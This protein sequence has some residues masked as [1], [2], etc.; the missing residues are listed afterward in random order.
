VGE[1]ARDRQF[2]RHP[3]DIPIEIRRGADSPAPVGGTDT[4]HV[5]NVSVGGLAVDM[6]QCLD[7]GEIVEIHIPFVKPPFEAHGRVVWCHKADGSYEMGV[8]FL[9][10]SDAFRARMVE[11]VCHI[12][13]YKRDVREKEGRVLATN[14][15]AREW[16]TK[17][18]ARF[19]K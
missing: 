3:A 7:K 17:F 1:A 18:A 8:Q 11:Q 14:E 6:E 19:P 16:I 9:D 12:E 10:A 5:Q 2:Y 4:A 13:Q 15:A